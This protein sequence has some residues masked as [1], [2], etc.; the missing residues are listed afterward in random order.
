MERTFLMIKPD[1]VQRKLVGEIITRLEKKG[2]KLVGGKF[3]TVSKE[4]AETHYGEH[5]DKPFY[6]GLVSFITSA[7]VFA[8]VVEGENVVE[9][10][11]NMIGKTNPTEAAPGTIRGDLGLTVGRNVIHGSDSVES[12]KREISLWFEPNELSVYT[13]NDEEW[14]Y[15]N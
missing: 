11:R 7:P 4:K 6:D 3:M 8:M 13:A 5:A 9:V 2:L 14:L 12:A 1:G 10:T 15:E